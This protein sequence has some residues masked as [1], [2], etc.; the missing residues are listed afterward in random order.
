MQSGLRDH[1][2]AKRRWYYF[3][4][5]QMDVV[6]QFKQFESDTALLGR[7]TFHTAF[8]DPIVIPDDPERQSIECRI[9]LFFLD[10]ELNTCPVLPSDAVA[11]EVA[12][13][14]E[15]GTWDISRV[16][17]L[18]EWMRN[19]AYFEVLVG[20]MLVNLGMKFP[21]ITWRD[22]ATTAAIVDLTVLRTPRV[23][24][25]IRGNYLCSGMEYLCY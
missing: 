7:M 15:R 6:S 19:D 23:K 21:E 3:P 1:N 11:K 5:I 10:L 17:K 12:F 4:K 2:A 8:V 22:P 18:S 9:F 20:S 25:K 16:R 24:W 14:A 13:H